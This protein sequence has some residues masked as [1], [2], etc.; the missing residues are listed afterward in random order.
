MVI[1]CDCYQ[2]PIYFVETNCDV[3]QQIEKK[4]LREYNQFGDARLA[5]FTPRHHIP[6]QAGLLELLHMQT[7]VLTKITK[8]GTLP[9]LPPLT[10]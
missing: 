6:C 7:H 2:H 1:V 4:K 10:G 5:L 8:M 9:P 3:R